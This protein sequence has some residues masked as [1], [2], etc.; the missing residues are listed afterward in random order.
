MRQ[1]R[2]TYVRLLHPYMTRLTRAVSLTFTTGP[3]GPSSLGLFG[4]S[5]YKVGSEGPTLIF[6]TA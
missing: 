1:Q 2:F 4:A 6:R 5:S 3:F